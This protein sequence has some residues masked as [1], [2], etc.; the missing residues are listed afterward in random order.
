MIQ[1]YPINSLLQQPTH[2]SAA[3]RRLGRRGDWSPGLASRA[4]MSEHSPAY[5]ESSDGICPSPLRRHSVGHL[6][7]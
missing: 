7:A 6:L 5:P 4:A 1:V 2:E 3:S